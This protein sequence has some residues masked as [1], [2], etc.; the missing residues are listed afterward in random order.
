METYA[1]A[2][3]VTGGRPLRGEVAVHSAKNSALYL[4]LAGLL[5]PEPVVLKAVPRLSDVLAMCELIEH[6][7]AKT[8]WQGRDLH[9]DASHLVT[10]DAPY[11]LVSRLRA[12]FVAMGALI[13]RCGEAHISMPGGCAFGPRPVDRHLKAF[14]QLGIAL[15][16][17]KGDFH[18]QRNQPLEGRIVF[19]APTVGGTQNVILASV[20][21]SEQVVIEN[22]ALEPEI[23]DLADMLT[24]M[25]ARI[26]GAGT[27]TIVIDGVAQLSG[28]TFQP[29]PDRI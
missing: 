24:Q 29:L 21:G 3:Y 25:G 6:F 4:I 27:P 13:G 9:I 8:A 2:F 20:L 26:S 17:V 18:A 10:T 12:S 15:S 11:A 28:V 19:D 1:E 22:A 16:E 14:R 23:A 7:G 5:T